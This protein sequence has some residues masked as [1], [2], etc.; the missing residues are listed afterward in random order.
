M[1]RNAQKAKRGFP[2]RS[3]LPKQNACQQARGEQLRAMNAGGITL[4]FVSRHQVAFIA[5]EFRDLG[6]SSIHTE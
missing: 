1:M 2:A 3:L 4:S 6:V 5:G